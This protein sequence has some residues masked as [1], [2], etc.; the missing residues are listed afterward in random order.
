MMATAW[1]LYETARATFR[2]RQSPLGTQAHCV[3]QAFTCSRL[4]GQMFDLVSDTKGGLNTFLP[5]ELGTKLP[6]VTTAVAFLQ[7]G[8]AWRRRQDLLTALSGRPPP[9]GMATCPPLLPTARE[10]PHS[11]VP[12]QAWE[13]GDWGHSEKWGRTQPPGG[14]QRTLS[15][16]QAWKSN[17]NLTVWS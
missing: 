3:L 16:M 14:T 8:L 1:D 9:A 15:C 2:G 5:I 6:G 7:Q 10:M 17:G 13:G 4:W 12:D 11:L